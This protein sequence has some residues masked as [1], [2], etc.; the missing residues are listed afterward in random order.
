M[1]SIPQTAKTEPTKATAAE[2]EIELRRMMREMR[3]VLVAYSGGVD[4]TYLGFIA[5]RE[6]GANAACVMGISPSVSSFQRSEAKA[7]ARSAGFDF[8]TVETFETADADYTANAGDRCYFCKAELYAVLRSQA[9]SRDR[10]FILDGTNADD[11]SGHRPGLKA[12]RENNVR[13]PLAEAGFTKEEI[14][15]QSRLHGL[16]SWDKPASPCLSSRIA[17]GIPVTIGRLSQVEQA[18]AIIRAKGFTEFRVRVHGDL[19]RIE[20]DLSE[21]SMLL[22]AKCVAEITKSFKPLGFRHITLDLEG[23]RS[24]STNGIDS[25]VPTPVDSQKADLEKV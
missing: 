2:K 14:R 20:L 22:D 7:A 16:R 4:S 18:E 19:A 13:S 3:T 11:L 9:A 23:F 8:D 5:N 10:A 6:L 12:A 17:V 15:S 25:R 24:G 1:S 21:M